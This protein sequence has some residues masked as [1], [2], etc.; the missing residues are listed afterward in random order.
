MPLLTGRH[1][2]ARLYAA[3]IDE[4]EEK[5]DALRAAGFDCAGCTAC[6]Y[7]TCPL[8]GALRSASLLR[9]AIG[10]GL[11]SWADDRSLAWGTA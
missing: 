7:R 1:P 6:E 4:A 9:K 5:R 2:D 10:P 8:A 11:V 3:L